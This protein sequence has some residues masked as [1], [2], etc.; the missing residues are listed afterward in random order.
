MF[1]MGFSEILL[2]AIIAIL[3]LGPDK[4]PEAMVQ[5]AKFLNSFKKAVSEAKASFEEEIQIRELREEA[6]SYRRTLEKST[7]DIRGFKHAIPNP[8]KEVSK[9]LEDLD[10]PFNGRGIDDEDF[11]QFAENEPA[12]PDIEADTET[13]TDRE[14]I[15]TDKNTP[16]NISTTQDT[17]KKKKKSGKTERKTVSGKKKRIKTEQ[18]DV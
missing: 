3:F 5:I 4:L 11:E 9:V 2:I 18:S 6:L 13:D 12:E 1:G 17:E 10:D 15:N 14:T 7:E 8:A 16:K